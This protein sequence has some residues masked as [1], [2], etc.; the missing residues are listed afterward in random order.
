MLVVGTLA[1]L[2]SV[3]TDAPLGAVGGAVLLQILSSILDQIEALGAIRSSCRRT[4]TTP[5]WGCFRP[6]PDRRR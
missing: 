6:R 3:S 5:G 4:S 2:L 1:F